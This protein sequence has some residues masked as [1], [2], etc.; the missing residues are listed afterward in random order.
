MSRNG[1]YDVVSKT[2]VCER[3]SSFDVDGHVDVDVCRRRVG[4]ACAVAV[5]VH[6]HWHWQQQT[7]TGRPPYDIS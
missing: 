1:K 4:D 3:R 2:G 7:S 5:G 6:H